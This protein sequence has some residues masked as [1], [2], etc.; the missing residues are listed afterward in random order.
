MKRCLSC[1]IYYMNIAHFDLLNREC[2]E[3]T[4]KMEK[5]EKRLVFKCCL[6]VFCLVTDYVHVTNVGVI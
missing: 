5:L 3:P 6:F 1:L 2:A 4:A